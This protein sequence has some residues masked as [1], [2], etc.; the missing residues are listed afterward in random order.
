MNF[1]SENRL[2]FPSDLGALDRWLDGNREQAFRDGRENQT[3]NEW[4]C[5]RQALRMPEFRELIGH[6][7]H[8]LKS[9]SEAQGEA[10]FTVL[11]ADGSSFA[12]EVTEATVP[13]DRKAIAKSRRANKTMLLLGEDFE[14]EEGEFVAG[15]R[16]ADGA[17]GD[18]WEIAMAEDIRSALE[19][20]CKKPYARDAVLIVYPN[21]NAGSADRRKVKILLEGCLPAATFRAIFVIHDGPDGF[22]VMRGGSD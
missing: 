17:E 7:G 9:E 5:I 20:K 8:I 11:T 21:S 2:R 12:L 4:W 1:R 6:S 16:F 13:S 10:D 15:G 14:T 19:R 18:E 22:E 3:F